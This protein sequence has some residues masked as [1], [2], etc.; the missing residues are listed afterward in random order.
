MAS[1][2]GGCPSKVVAS[3]DGV[4]LAIDP[5]YAMMKAERQIAIGPDG[6]ADETCAP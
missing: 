5:F 6:K 2:M 3:A 4:T 1:V